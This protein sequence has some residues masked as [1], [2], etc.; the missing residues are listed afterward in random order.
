MGCEK[1]ETWG[2]KYNFCGPFCGKEFCLL[3]HVNLGPPSLNSFL[4]KTKTLFHKIGRE[5]N[6]RQFNETSIKK[7][8]NKIQHSKPRK[9]NFKIWN[10]K[11]I[12]FS[13]WIINCAKLQGS[14][15]KKV[16]KIIVN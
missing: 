12:K 3:L 1:I 2:T 6:A 11:E 7:I 14:R 5:F 15:C 16:K 13:N 8:K 4:T 9:H 10:W